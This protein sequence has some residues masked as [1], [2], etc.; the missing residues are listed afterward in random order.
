MVRNITQ[1]E[2]EEITGIRVPLLDLFVPNPDGTATATREFQE[3]YL[4]ENNG[5]IP[6]AL[7]NYARDLRN[8]LPKI[9]T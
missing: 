6:T 8:S 9:E 2:L 4:L 1:Q 5:D 7:E 3:T